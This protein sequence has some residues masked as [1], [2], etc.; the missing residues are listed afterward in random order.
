[1]SG[2]HAQR[3]RDT[4]AALSGTPTIVSL[5]DVHGHLDRARSALLTLSDHD[6]FDPIVEEREDGGLDWAGNDYVLVFNGDMIDRGP[7]SA[8][9]LSLVRR[10]REAAPEGRVRYHIGNHETFLLYPTPD[11]DR[12]Y[13]DRVDDAERR[14]FYEEIR[15]GDVSVAYEG[16]DHTFVHAGAPD[17]VDAASVNDD[18][19]AAAGS[20]VG[21]VGTGEDRSEHQRLF[22]AYGHVLMYGD[23]PEYDGRGPGAGVVWLDFE[24]LPGGSPPQVVGHTRHDAVT[25]TGNVVC[26]DVILNNVGAPG[27]EAVV[28]ETPDSLRALV[29]Q[30]DGSVALREV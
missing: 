20:L 9:C 30:E 19:T 29:R 12:W 17:G 1:M 4:V 24:H 10:L 26:G 3:P 11:R 16:Y 22:E 18:L 14:N 23:D 21:V 8:G 25:R 2:E 6:A 15:A 27:G 7:D 5:S 13:C 28:V